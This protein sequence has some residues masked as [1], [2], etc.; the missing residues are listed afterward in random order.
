MRNA[1]EGHDQGAF[2]QHGQFGLEISVAAANLGR[3]RLVARGQALHRIADAAIDETKAVA[4]RHGFRARGETVRVQRAVQ[5]DSGVIAGKGSSGPV[6]AM[7][8]R[9]ESHDQQAMTRAAEGRH[10]A[11]VI[12]RMSV[13]HGVEK[14]G[15]PRAKP[16]IRIEACALHARK[17]AQRALNCASSVEPRMAVIE[18]VPAVTVCVTS[19]K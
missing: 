13:S 19:S 17:R 9:R 2:W 14:A 15:E 1:A 16:A 11:A 6:R 3:Q 5:Q 18:E 12:L 7:Q 10:R 4:G 8:A